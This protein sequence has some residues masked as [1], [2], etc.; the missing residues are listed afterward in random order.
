MQIPGVLLM[1]FTLGILFDISGTSGL[2]KICSSVCPCALI[3]R[4]CVL[5]TQLLDVRWVVNISLVLFVL[6]PCFAFPFLS[7]LF[8]FFFLFFSLLFSFR[9]SSPSLVASSLFFSV[10]FPA[11]NWRFSSWPT[12][13]S[14]RGLVPQFEHHLWRMNHVLLSTSQCGHVPWD[15][16][17]RHLL[18]ANIRA[19]L[20][21]VNSQQGPRPYYIGWS[22]LSQQLWWFS[23]TTRCVSKALDLS[24]PSATPVPSR[25]PQ[26]APLYLDLQ[27]KA[28]AWLG[29]AEFPSSPPSWGQQGQ[30]WPRPSYYGQNT[31]TPPRSSS[32]PTSCPTF[33]RTPSTGGKTVSGRTPNMQWG[34]TGKQM[35]NSM[36]TRK[37]MDCL[38]LE[39]FEVPAGANSK[40]L[41]PYCPI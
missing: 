16:G 38:S 24:Q 34:T 32:Q 33:S 6:S 3:D 30:V 9:A 15:Q 8:P 2:P 41:I 28:V 29:D 40:T 19:T 17:H 36:T 4:S 23:R 12:W 39:L 35:R 25:Q 11:S 37:S 7:F 18:H 5:Q 20:H 27:Y 1:F 14:W 13:W 31:P 22:S 21:G 10:A 26:R